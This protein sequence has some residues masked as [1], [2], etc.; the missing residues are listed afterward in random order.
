MNTF[1]SDAIFGYTA[2]MK[3]ELKAMLSREQQ[4]A[5]KHEEVELDHA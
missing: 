4:D 1:V 2:K 3:G 5:V